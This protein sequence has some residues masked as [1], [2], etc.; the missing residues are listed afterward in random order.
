MNVNLKISSCDS[1]IESIVFRGLGVII[2]EVY[3]EK[4]V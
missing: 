2:M 1:N 4:Y 3:D